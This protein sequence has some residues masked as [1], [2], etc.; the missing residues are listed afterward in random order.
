MFVI[1]TE[2]QKRR[3]IAIA[4]KEFVKVELF[5]L[6]WT[7][8]LCVPPVYNIKYRRTI[9]INCISTLL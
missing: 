4:K 6:R 9:H 7:G 2:G 1:E 8:C 5:L 3:K